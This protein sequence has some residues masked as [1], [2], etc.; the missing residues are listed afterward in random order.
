ME[1]RPTR[2]AARLR[3]LARHPFSPGERKAYREHLRT[4]PLAG[5]TN[6][7]LVLFD[8]VVPEVPAQLMAAPQAA[9][10]QVSII[11]PVHN[12]LDFTLRCLMAIAAH[13][14]RASAEI[15]VC[16]DAS[17][18]ATAKVLG[19][20]PGIRYLRNAANLGFLQTCNRAAEA[21]RGAYLVF[22][23]NDTQVQA[24]WLDEML[25]LLEADEQ[26]GLVGAKLVF[27]DG[28]LQEAGARIWR[29][30]SGHHIGRYD[31]PAR[32]E[33]N[34]VREVDYCS[35][36]CLMIS[37]AL[38]HGLG[39]FDIRYAPAYYEDTDLAFRVRAAGRK[40]LYQPKAVVVH[41]EGV[42]HGTDL[43]RGMKAHQVANQGKF[44]ERW[45]SVLEEFHISRP[46]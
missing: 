41:H 5:V 9:P 34:T 20:L 46:E 26:A 40:V 11:I 18:D 17:T 1:E 16:D 15:V 25:A 6:A 29:D 4:L 7:G 38:F 28:R 19:A 32:A 21:A 14:S 22:L 37:A 36:A 42:S 44:R 30:G 27:P 3:A 12:Q 24:G 35:G 43:S 33:Y 13:R 2:S 39:G 10:P 23:N 8:D 31:D 45:H